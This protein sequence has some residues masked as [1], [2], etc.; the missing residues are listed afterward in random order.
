MQFVKRFV[1]LCG[2][3][4]L[5]TLT[6]PAQSL[7]ASDTCTV[8]DDSGCWARYYG[9]GTNPDGEPGKVFYRLIRACQDG[10]QVAIANDAVNTATIYATQ[11]SGV[12]VPHVRK[13]MEP[14]VITLNPIP[15]GEVIQ[16]QAEGGDGT[17]FDATIYYKRIINFGYLNSPSAAYGNDIF[18]EDTGYGQ[19][20]NIGLGLSV[21]L[22]NCYL[23]PVIKNVG[24]G[25]NSLV[26][27]VVCAINTA[28]PSVK[29]RFGYQN[30]TGY[31]AVIPVGQHNVFTS[32]G[33]FTYASQKL[34]KVFPVGTSLNAMTREALGTSISW[35]LGNTTRS[36]ATFILPTCKG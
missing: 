27:T 11:Y 31:D 17:I 7:L 32:N 33:A 2:L 21:N 14:T 5:L 35:T 13:L 36:S 29:Y 3:F 8:M 23:F 28:G 16:S 34:P 1:F 9:A 25:H 12:L 15:G 22:E 10:V 4:V 18:L 24:I 6:L 30:N 20:S 26:P 19:P